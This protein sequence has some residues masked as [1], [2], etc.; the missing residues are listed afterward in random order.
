MISTRRKKNKLYWW[1][2]VVAMVFVAT[3]VIYSQCYRVTP[4]QSSSSGDS[5]TPPSAPS[6]EG[7]S[8][9]AEAASTPPPDSTS[10]ASATPQSADDYYQA[11][12]EK[13]NDKDYEGAIKDI[14][15]AI[16]LN[17]KVPDYYNKKSQ[18]EYNLGQKDQAI[19]TTQE[20]LKNNPDSEL[21]KSRLDILQKSSFTDEF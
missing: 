3:I 19:A 13:F 8:S 14:E 20:G 4:T 1:L 17:N 16:S 9:S 6:I 15:R 18:A 12:I 10:T 21:L 7:L 2:F 5:A 11:G